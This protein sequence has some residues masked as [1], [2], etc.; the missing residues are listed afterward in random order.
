M[1]TAQVFVCLSLLNDH[2]CA[3]AAEKLVLAEG[4]KMVMVSL[5]SARSQ[6]ST[7]ISDAGLQMSNVSD[8]S[9][10]Q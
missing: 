3:Q 10:E 1:R 7:S 5:Q 6:A 9:H 4:S 2:F 8:A